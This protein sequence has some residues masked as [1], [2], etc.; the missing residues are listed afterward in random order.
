MAELLGRDPAEMVGFNALS[1][2]DEVGQVQLLAHL[3]EL[4]SGGEPGDNLECSLLRKDGSRLEA[5]ISH[6]PIIDDAGH[7]R[8]W[9]H[10]V[11]EFTQQR[12]LLDIIQRREHQLAE[13]QAIAKVGSWEWDVAGDKVTWSDELFRIY[14]L[15]PRHFVPTY[16]GF[17]DGIHPEDR[18]R[19]HATVTGV[20]EAGMDFEFD[21][22][23]VRKSGSL[24]WI[25]GRGRRS[26]RPPT[27]P[28]HWPRGS[29]S[30]CARSVATPPGK[31]RRPTSW[32]P[33]RGWSS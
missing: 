26:R 18:E 21:A 33:T 13:A 25:R 3:H 12:Q 9:L 24:G 30:R 27:T 23:I 15:D 20:F 2:L 5:L 14:E 7:R 1:A 11:S 31:R 19:V 17:I 16:A 32:D 8:G 6:T 4:Q 10:R 22:R 29:P 28:T